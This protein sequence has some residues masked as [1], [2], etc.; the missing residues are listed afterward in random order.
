AMAA[1]REDLGA[2]KVEA[3]HFEI[4]MSRVKPSLT[5]EI[6]KYFEEVKKTLRA[7]TIPEE[8]KEETYVY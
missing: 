6:L 1:L 2:D 4:A 3:R 8:R 5:D 7:I